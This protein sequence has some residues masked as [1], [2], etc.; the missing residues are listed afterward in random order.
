MHVCMLVGVFERNMSI[1]TYV[2]TSMQMQVRKLY[3]IG[4]SFAI[5]TQFPDFASVSMR[6]MSIIQH[7]SRSVSQR[8]FY[9]V[10]SVDQGF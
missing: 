7:L 10:T 2:P 1:Q 9:G 8:C 3:Q 5:L 6:Q 4:N